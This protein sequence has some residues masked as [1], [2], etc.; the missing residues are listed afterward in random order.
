MAVAI[1]RSWCSDRRFY[2]NLITNIKSHKPDGEVGVRNIREGLSRWVSRELE[3]P[4][5]G[6]TWLLTS[7]AQ[8]VA[9]IKTVV[10]ETG[11]AGLLY[12]WNSFRAQRFHQSSSPFGPSRRL[13]C[14]AVEYLLSSEYVVSNLVRG[15]VF[16]VVRESGMGHRHPGCIGEREFAAR[17]Q[18]LQSSGIKRYYRY[19]DDV[20]MICSRKQG[21]RE[22]FKMLREKVQPF[23]LQ[24]E[25]E[26]HQVRGCASHQDRNQVRCQ[27][28][29]QDNIS[30]KTRGSDISTSQIRSLQ[31]ASWNGQAHF[32]IV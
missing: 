19:R 5:T 28:S 27:A 30:C 29:L 8:L 6:H 4:L 3:G 23:K 1:N 11:R 22:F 13:L 16:R 24:A 14:E 2:S 32:P 20:F 21:T 25:E 31:L 17:S 18:V 15:R 7:S 26:Q 12:D 10:A 9:D